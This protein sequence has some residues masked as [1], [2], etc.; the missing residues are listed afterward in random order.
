MSSTQ[1]LRRKS[2]AATSLLDRSFPGLSLGRRRSE[3][4]DEVRGSL[5]L[6]LLYAPSEPLIDFIFV[7]GLR[8]G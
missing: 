3:H 8:G 6:N 1:A 7:H 2:A 5:G 4:A